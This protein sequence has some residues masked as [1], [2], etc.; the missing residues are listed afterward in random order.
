MSTE[1]KLLEQLRWMGFVDVDKWQFGEWNQHS[2][3]AVLRNV[4]HAPEL[5]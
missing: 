2:L 3:L 5:E 4:P 1:K